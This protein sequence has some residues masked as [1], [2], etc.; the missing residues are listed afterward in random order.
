MENW[1]TE[2]IIVFLESGDKT[3]IVSQIEF[4]LEQVRWIQMSLIL[5]FL[6]GFPSKISTILIFYFAYQKKIL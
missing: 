1:D 5:I 6:L 2:K 3:W 4:D